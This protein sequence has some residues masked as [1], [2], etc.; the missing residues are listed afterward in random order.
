MSLTIDDLL[1]ADSSSDEGFVENTDGNGVPDGT[2]TQNSITPHGGSHSS[3]QPFRTELTIEEAL[4]QNDFSD[5]DCEAAKT[6]YIDFRGDQTPSDD[7][8]DALSPVFSV[9]DDDVA[10]LDEI[11]ARD[12]D[13]SDSLDSS[14]V[15]SKHRDP[16]KTLAVKSG[17]NVPAAEPYSHAGAEAFMR[18][19]FESC[20]EH[21]RSM[22]FAC[23]EDREPVVRDVTSIDTDAMTKVDRKI[24]AEFRKTSSHEFGLPTCVVAHTQLVGVGTLRGAVVLMDPKI[25]DVA[26]E[27]QVLC[28]P[29]NEESVPVTAA[30]FAPDG[31]SILVGHKNGQLILWDLTT[32]KVISIMKDVHSCPVLSVA[33][34]RAIL[35]IS[36]DA[37]GTVVSLTFTSTFGRRDCTRQKLI[38]PFSSIGIT[39]RV[40]PVPPVAQAM[41]HAADLHCVV[42]L[43]AT[44][45][46]VFLAMQPSVQLLRRMQYD[47]KDVFANATWIPDVTWLRSDVQSVESSENNTPDPLLCIGFGHQ[48]HI[49]CVSYE[50]ATGNANGQFK[51]SLSQRFTWGS[52]IQSVASFSKGVIAILD[53]SSKL[54]IVQLPCPSSSTSKSLQPIHTQDVGNWSLAYHTHTCAETG[55]QSRAHHRSLAI[56]RGRNRTLYVCG[57]RDVWSMEIRRWKH[58]I[59]GLVNIRNWTAALD[60][61]HGLYRE[62]LPPL[63]DFPQE[64]PMLQK[65]VGS[66]T[67]QL[68]QSY[69]QSELTSEMPRTQVRQ[70]CFMTVSACVEM[71]LWSVLYKT[72]F[73]CFKASGHMN[74]YCNTLE[75]F[76]VDGKI[77]RDEMDSEVLS[78]ILQSYALLLEEEE[79]MALQHMK[80]QEAN[81]SRLSVFCG[82]RS[83]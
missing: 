68:I 62:T 60:V 16:G 61:L 38:E 49:V 56:F 14:P 77:P 6:T 67:I 8:G 42:A 54:S 12:S 34:C 53:N 4:A 50:T 47:I 43:C 26:A 58:Q 20:L 41:I 59:E 55:T 39:L 75:P 31:N 71:K 13:S 52:Q 25:R 44:K 79:Q 10:R 37:H 73:E 70:M 7:T 29:G 22:V 1:A 63:L 66:R 46:T 78:S 32:L 33:F 74:V 9:G 40:L 5:D 35:A 69:L 65:A 81:G 19:P 2:S 57:A 15:A 3:K 30:A 64:L 72:V 80:E 28:Q 82:L 36:A 21:E 11:L 51:I 24:C 83:F 27:P 48:L 76:I 18:A 23:V 45:A 17:N